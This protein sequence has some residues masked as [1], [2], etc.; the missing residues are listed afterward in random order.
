MNAKILVNE[1][2]IAAGSAISS[3]NDAMEIINSQLLPAL[4]KL[5]IQ[6]TDEVIID[7]FAGT[8]K[9]EKAY[10]ETVELDLKKIANPAI[11]ESLSMTAAGAWGSFENALMPIRKEVGSSYQYLAPVDGRLVLSDLSIERIREQY[12]R[13]ITSPEEIKAHEIHLEI[14]E[15]LNLLFKGNIPF[16]WTALFSIDATG[17]FLVNEDTNYV[18]LV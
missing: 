3:A 4:E 2:A 1:N 11:R 10:F 14:V 13:Y 6:I 16:N 18:K 17:S 5:G 7:L 12:R 8:N 9:T 15:K